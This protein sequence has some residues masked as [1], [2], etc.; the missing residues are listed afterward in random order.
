MN[1]CNFAKII[2]KLKK[3]TLEVFYHLWPNFRTLKVIISGK[4]LTLPVYVYD[5]PNDSKALK[6]NTCTCAHCIV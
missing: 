2:K 5:E 6:N 3:D 4:M 1:E